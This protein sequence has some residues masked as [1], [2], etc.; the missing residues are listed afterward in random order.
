MT[1]RP[2]V[3]AARFVLAHVPDLVVSGSKPRRE[4]AAGG[5]D[6]RQA[7]RARRRGFADAVAYPP[8]QVMIGNLAPEALRKIGRPWH[9]QPM[10]GGR[11]EGP[12]GAIIDEPTFYA[13]LV[14]ADTARL[15]RLSETFAR[16]ISDRLDG[17]RVSTAAAASLRELVRA[18]AEPFYDEYGEV[19]GIVL[20]G[21][22]QDEALAA[23]ILLENLATKVTGALALR[24]L[25]DEVAT[26]Q[27]VDFLLGCGE[28]AVGDR[29]QR[30]G[31]NL[32]KAIGEQA[33]LRDAGGADIKAFCAGPVHALIMAGGLVASGLYRRVVVVAGGSLAKL[34]MKFQGHLS[35]GYPVL[36]DV[37]AGVAI[38]VT[39]DDG[40]SP[41]MRLDAATTHR[42]GD[43][44][45]PHQMAAAL[46]MTPL[47]AHG[48]RLG[49]VDR[50]AVELHNPD[51]TEPAGSGDVP[52]RNYH[53]IAALAVQA[54][55][56]TRA[57]M[58]EFVEA[59]GLP[60]F[61]PTQGHIPS[62]IPYVPHA[63]VGLTDGSL[64][65]V[66]LVAKGSL[67]LGRMTEMA[68]G[69]S[70]LLERR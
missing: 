24:R 59:H 5:E 43:G 47:R 54:G 39:A 65:R 62:A 35:A 52:T 37:L 20:P 1:T 66:Q 40:R 68:D 38:D 7:L 21:H 31:G 48:L 69:A 16:R 13:W 12:A 60:G 46:T 27:P 67:F 57:Q 61:S 42:I 19:A 26:D 49:D 53:M 50:Y 11:P 9:D 51:I 25:L 28:E 15:V 63:L 18:G 64:T 30:G 2:V 58:S 14:R 32:A 36:E 56:I 44:A 55:E 41:V 17:T 33:G 3:R 8:H 45:A 4:L 70:V 23:A 6:L 34:G 22:E 10:V 29:Y